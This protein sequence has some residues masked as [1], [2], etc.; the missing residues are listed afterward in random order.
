[1]V[2]EKWKKKKRGNKC[3][4]RRKVSRKDEAFPNIRNARTRKGQRSKKKGTW[5]P[6]LTARLYEITP[7]ANRKEGNKG[8]KVKR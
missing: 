5:S 4:E 6:V 8:T 7:R 3:K 1:M 2:T